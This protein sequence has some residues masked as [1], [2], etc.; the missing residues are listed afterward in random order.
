M[1]D[2]LKAPGKETMSRFKAQDK[3][4][5][6]AVPLNNYDKRRSITRIGLAFHDG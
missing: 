4:R 2:N 1:L 3:A 5:E 6:K